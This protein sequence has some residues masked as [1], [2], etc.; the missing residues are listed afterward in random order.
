MLYI[1]A[2]PYDGW[3]ARRW[4]NLL[5]RKTGKGKSGEE[6]QCAGYQQHHRQD[7]GML[8]SLLNDKL[9]VLEIVFS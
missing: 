3:S 9:S 7:E 6:V 5:G 1:F 2:D 4:Q 8:K